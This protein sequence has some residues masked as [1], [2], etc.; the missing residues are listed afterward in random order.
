MDKWIT[1]TE[2]NWVL[3]IA[4]LFALFELFR[5]IY[6]GGEWLVSK[7]GFETKKSLERKEWNKRL[8]KTEN[9]IDEIKK[10][11]DRNVK[12]FLE[13]E[14][15]VVSKFSGIRDEI[16]SEIIKLHEKIDEQKTEMDA[17]NEANI[18]TDCAM[19][20]DRIASGMRYFGQNKDE[21]GVVHISFSD[22]ENMEALFQE[23]FA[24]H[25][26]GT[27]HHMYEHEFQH[28]IVDM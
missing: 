7:F 13:H 6:T 27:F 28:F 22:H 2:Y 1:I 4:G 18:K 20:R 24:K 9:D 25:G 11:S 26:N 17:T 19:L 23:Y 16:I 15:A 12:M 21:H 3:W 14:Q 10:N 5:W 8:S